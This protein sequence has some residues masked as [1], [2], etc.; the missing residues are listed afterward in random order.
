MMCS[1]CRKKKDAVP[2]T[3][4]EA[5]RYWLFERFFV[6]EIKSVQGEAGAKAFGDGYTIGL[7]HANDMKKRY[8]EI[9]EQGDIYQEVA[10]ESK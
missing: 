2:T 9:R 4:W 10:P 7:N 1:A 5:I 6:E 3:H 8:E